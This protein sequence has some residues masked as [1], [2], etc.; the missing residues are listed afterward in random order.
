MADDCCN[1]GEGSCAPPALRL[2]EPQVLKPRRRDSMRC[3]CG[4][5]LSQRRAPLRRARSAL[6]TRALDS[7]RHQRRDVSH[8]NDRGPACRVPGAQSRRFRFS[9][10]YRHYGL[11]LA[12]R[13]TLRTRAMAALFKGLSLSLMAFWVFGSTIYPPQ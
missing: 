10:R 9:R 4:L 5:R 3:G 2:P 1:F 12:V 13:S 8:G 11:S 7:D 6:Q